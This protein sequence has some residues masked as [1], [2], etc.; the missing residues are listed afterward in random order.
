LTNTKQNLS[1][2]NV[3]RKGYAQHKVWHYW[4]VTQLAFNFTNSIVLQFGLDVINLAYEYNI[5]NIAII[6]L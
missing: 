1:L 6:G 5:S 2:Q 4:G 3:D